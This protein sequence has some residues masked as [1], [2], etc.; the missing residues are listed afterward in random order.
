MQLQNIIFPTETF[1]YKDMYFRGGE[2]KNNKLV[3]KQ[4][5]KAS[6]DTYFNSF[7]YTLYRDY[8]TVCRTAFTARFSGRAMVQLCV[9]D[10]A[11]HIVAECEAENRVEITADFSDLPQKG[12]MY[13]KFVAASEFE[14]Y[15]CGYYSECDYRNVNVCIGICTYKR[16]EYVVKNLEIL[17]SFDFSLINRVFVSD[18][19]N[20]LDCVQLSDDFITVSKNKNYGGSGGFTR[21]MI[22]AYEGGYSHIIV[23]DDDVVFHPEILERMTA[24]LSILSPENTG[25]HISAAML[26][27]SQPFMQYEAG[28]KWHGKGIEHLGYNFDVRD[29]NKLLENVSLPVPDYGG[30]WCFCL[31]TSDIA[32]NRLPYPFFIKFDDA[33]FGIRNREQGRIITMNGIAVIHEDFEMK[34]SSH[35]EYYNIRN[36]MVMNAVSLKRSFGLAI[37][38]LVAST[39]KHLFLYRYDDMPI[40]F[41]AFEDFLAGPEF[42]IAAQDDK[43]NSEIMAMRTKMQPLSEI[44]GWGSDKCVMADKLPRHRLLSAV[45]LGGHIIPTVF[46]KKQIIC[47]PISQINIGKCVGYRSTIQFQL[48]SPEGIRLDRSVKKFFYWFFK[49][50]GLAFKLCFYYGRTKKRYVREK[51]EITSVEFWREKLSM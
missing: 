51:Y 13:A 14:L 32:E 21:C 34:Y 8:T 1:E 19:G 25:L 22:E 38:R 18:N 49:T 23:M 33:E 44:N 26:P 47:A 43:I 30:W 27:M 31:P 42:F 28:A 11:E 4:G 41:R 17:R 39:V 50:I 6:F 35:L 5:E 10:G 24:F 9:F 36:Q 45:T 2:L 15:D 3:L 20:T 29:R 37:R 40:V 12:F 46:M 48:G 16:E 7:S